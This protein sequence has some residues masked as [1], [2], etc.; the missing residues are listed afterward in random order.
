MRFLL[1]T[2]GVLFAALTTVAQRPTP[3]PLLTALD[4]DGD[5]KLSAA[6]IAAAPQ[7]LATLDRDADG[8][9]SAT[10][11][12]PRPAP[13]TAEPRAPDAS[14][15]KPPLA[16]DDA[17]QQALAVL[18]DLDRDRRGHMN[19]PEADGRLLRLLVETIGAS[20]VVEI[21][22][23]NGYS[24]IWMSLGVRKSGGRI[25]TH[26]LD[27]ERAAVA[28]ANFARAGVAE[29]V[30]IVEGDAHQ[31]VKKLTAP[32]DLL[33]VDADKPGY[34]DYLQKLLP[35]VRPGGLIVGHNMRQ[36]SGDPKFLEAITTDPKLETLFLNMHAAGISVTLKKR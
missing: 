33:F 14:P 18:A 1:A 27:P 12:T 28:R 35:L 30:S 3:D 24:S 36:P 6:E 2:A 9:L 13:R 20:H 5:G 8:A 16:K 25:V 23:S 4:K 26:E 34:L 31:T 17:E 21:G 19:V 10:E 15:E 7:T 32:I 29:L 22:T 11:L